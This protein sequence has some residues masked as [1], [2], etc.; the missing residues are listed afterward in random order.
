MGLEPTPESLKEFAF[1][2]GYISLTYDLLV[3][4]AIVDEWMGAEKGER[5]IKGEDGESARIKDDSD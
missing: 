4:F 2:A 3:K 1:A 5:R